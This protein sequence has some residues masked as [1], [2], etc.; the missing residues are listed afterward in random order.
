MLSVSVLVGIMVCCCCF[1]FF[2]KH[3]ACSSTGHSHSFVANSN[4]GVVTTVRTV[5]VVPVTSRGTIMESSKQWSNNN[6]SAMYSD[7]PPPYS[8]TVR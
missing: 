5:E 2:K 3:G 8:E 1:F 6:S 7:P 4:R